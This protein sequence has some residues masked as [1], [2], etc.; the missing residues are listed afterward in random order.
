MGNEL[1]TVERTGELMTLTKPP[2]VSA[3]HD[4]MGRWEPEA[5]KRE[6]VRHG[7]DVPAMLAQHRQAMTASPT[8][9]LQKRLRLLWKSSNPGG[10]LDAAAWLHETGR[11]LQDIPQDILG[12]AIDDAVKNS[13]KGYMPGVGEIRQQ[14][15]AALTARKTQLLRLEILSRMADKPAPKPELEPELSEADHKEIEHLRKKFGLGEM[16]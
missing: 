14:A 1:Q 4:F 11:L 13:P 6:M 2:H 12:E 3:L 15:N 8:D 9:W 7:F 5:A 16:K 10:G